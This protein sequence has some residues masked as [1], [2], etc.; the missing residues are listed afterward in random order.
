M[1]Y[2]GRNGVSRPKVNLPDGNMIPS[3]FQ[4]MNQIN[5][6]YIKVI[7]DREE[8]P[9]VEL[10][11]NNSRRVLELLNEASLSTGYV[12]E[13]KIMGDPVGP[14]VLTRINFLLS[15][16]GFTQGSFRG[17]RRALQ[18][19]GG[20]ILWCSASAWSDILSMIGYEE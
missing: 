2:R 18:K 9:V 3:V 10:R 7:F 1:N 4:R 8:D 13:L 5:P 14:R 11:S 20:T 17:W 6:V 19:A 15:R 12:M 16:T